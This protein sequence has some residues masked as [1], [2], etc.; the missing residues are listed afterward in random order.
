MQREETQKLIHCFEYLKKHCLDIFDALNVMLEVLLLWRKDSSIFSLNPKVFKRVA[1]DFFIYHHINQ[2]LLINDNIKS[3]RIKKILMGTTLTL[4]VIEKFFYVITQQKTLNKLYYYS[5]PLQIN[6]LLVGLLDVQENEEVYNPCY[7]VG[8]IFLSLAKLQPKAR[9]FGEELDFKLAHIAILITKICDMDSKNLFINDLLKNPQFITDKGIK[10]FDKVLC[11]PPMYAYM[12]LEYL[13]KDVRFSQMGALAKHYSELIFLTHSLVHIKKRGVFIVRNQ[14]LQKSYSEAKIRQRLLEDRVIEA[15]IELPKNILPFQNHDLSIIV[16]APNSENILHI[17]ANNDFFYAKEGKYNCLRNL[18][19]L[20]DIFKNKKIGN[21]SQLTHVKDVRYDD[22]S[23]GTYVNPNMDDSGNTIEK[24]GFEVIRGQ[25]VYGSKEDEEISYFDI[26]IADFS[27]LG[28]T[29]KFENLKTRGNPKKI[30]KYALK[31]YDILLSLRGS[32]PKITILE[33]INF[34]CVANTGVVV[35]RHKD[36]KKNLALYC[37]FFTKQGQ[38]K[39]RSIYEKSSKESLN[40][41]LLLRLVLPHNYEI[42]YE[43]FFE[44]IL[45]LSQDLERLEKRILELRN[46]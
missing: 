32:M 11:N 41:E 9:I 3:S 7:G 22:L 40:I 37:Y 45:E 2:P 8:S 31:S 30:K 15:I 19:Y 5:T 13:K 43:R 23:V 28:F 21:Y 36:I 46:S 16:L 34:A 18:D 44:K 27:T 10:K 25:R 33:K 14:V 20:L 29:K 39:L 12:G 1:E 26:G 24:A 42:F 17:N 38:E 35:L 4:D 6:R